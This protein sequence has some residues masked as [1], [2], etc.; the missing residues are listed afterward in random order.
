MCFL[1]SSGFQPLPYPVLRIICALC[2]RAPRG[3]GTSREKTNC[4]PQR[5]NRTVKIPSKY[6]FL[7]KTFATGTRNMLQ[8]NRQKTPGWRS[9]VKEFRPK[10]WGVSASW[11]LLEG[12]EGPFTLY[13]S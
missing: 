2:L 13:L 5:E 11:S 6:G 3:L 4:V 10:C 12:V 1:M 9:P 8:E 7:Q